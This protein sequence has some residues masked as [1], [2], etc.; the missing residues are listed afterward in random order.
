[1]NIKSGGGK[2]PFILN[3]LLKV[4]LLF[5]VLSWGCGLRKV[6]KQ[7]AELLQTAHLDSSR[8]SMA[9]QVQRTEKLVWKHEADSTAHAYVL[10]IWPKGQ[11]SMSDQGVFTGEAE[12]IR[13][14]GQLINTKKS[15]QLRQQAEANSS[16]NSLKIKN[17]LDSKMSQKQALV[18]KDPSWLRALLLLALA[19]AIN[20]ALHFWKKRDLS[21]QRLL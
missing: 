1:M 4:F 6:E 2:L 16:L 14:Q 20:L 8:D 18:K 7:S 17:K 13:L 9:A 5:L 19:I 3:N 15:S 11:F 21:G 12:K 10:E